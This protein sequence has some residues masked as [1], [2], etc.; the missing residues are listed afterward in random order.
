MK[1]NLLQNK[2]N[3]NWINVFC[4][5]QKKTH[6]DLPLFYGILCLEIIGIFILYSASN[7]NI[8]LLWHQ[9]TSFFISCIVLFIFAQISIYRYQSIVP[10]IFGAV[11]LLLIIVISMG[12]A[13]RGV[14]RWLNF[15]LIRFQPSEIMK[16]VMPMM[17][18]WYLRNKIFPL[19]AKELLNSCIIISFYKL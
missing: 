9:I 19:H 17:L 10:W 11:L 7:Q 8:S 3:K 16:L 4:N 15:G 5:I 1:K 14:Y 13:S 6:L 2:L 12:V 18:S